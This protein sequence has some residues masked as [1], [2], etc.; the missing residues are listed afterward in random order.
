M[1]AMDATSMS[2]ACAQGTC[3]CV[4][5]SL[6][7]PRVFILPT[8]RYAPVFYFFFFEG[9]FSFAGDAGCLAPHACLVLRF[10]PTFCLLGKSSHTCCPIDTPKW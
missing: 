8:W 3:T 4:Q 2:R 6:C 1:G 7:P 9:A 5:V 10:L